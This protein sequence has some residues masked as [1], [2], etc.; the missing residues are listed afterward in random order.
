MNHSERVGFRNSRRSS[1]AIFLFA[2]VAALFA[3]SFASIGVEATPQTRL[4]GIRQID[5]RTLPLRSAGNDQANIPK[6]PNPPTPAPPPTRAECVIPMWLATES[7]RIDDIVLKLH[8]LQ[9]M[10]VAG[11]KKEAPSAD[12]PQQLFKYRVS[13]LSKVVALM[14]GKK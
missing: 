11:Y 4:P 5:R 1:L 8:T 10:D 13:I 9:K 3:W 6:T 14:E 12:C 2:L 7:A